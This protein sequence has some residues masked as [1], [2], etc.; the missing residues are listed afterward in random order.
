MKLRLSKLVS[1]CMLLTL[2]L[3]GGGDAPS[4]VA[5][6]PDGDVLPKWWY[7]GLPARA[8]PLPSRV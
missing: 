2:F 6:A 4:T 5:T 8:C 1:V 3:V 7:N